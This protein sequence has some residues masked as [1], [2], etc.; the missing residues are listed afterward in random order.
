MIS[1]IIPVYREQSNIAL[2]LQCLERLKGIQEV[3][4]IV[5]DGDNGTTLRAI[6]ERN[7]SFTLRTFNAPPGR[8]LQLDRGARAARGDIL[9]FLHVDTVLPPRGLRLIQQ[10]LQTHDAGAFSLKVDSNHYLLKLWV[11]LT[12]QR[13]RLFRDPY[14]DH[15]QF[16]HRETY[17]AVGGYEP[18]P[19]ME[20][21]AMMRTLKSGG[22][23]I[24]ILP[25]RVTT[26]ARRLKREGMFRRTVRNAYILWA[27]RLG[28][29]PHRLARLYRPNYD[30]I[31]KIL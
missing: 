30:K 6:P 23:E 24:K 1:I 25:Q 21:V 17:L 22:Y 15:V 14:G 2:C 12:N 27:Y 8:G 7:R 29:S 31:S 13:I 10:T 18:I 20:D 9:V 26:S 3:E 28:V 5:V 11:F 4:A 19:I 16:M